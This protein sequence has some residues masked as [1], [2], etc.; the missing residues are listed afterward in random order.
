[1][2]ILLNILLLVGLNISMAQD[3]IPTLLKISNY[4][5]LKSFEL[6]AVP[7]QDI[8]N[9]KVS[10][11][12]KTEETI[13]E[14]PANVTV[15]EN[16]DIQR[17]GYYTLENL[18][19]ITSGYS[20]NYR[21]GEAGLETRGQTAQGFNNNKHL[22]LIDG[23]PINFSRSYKAQIMEELPLLFAQRVEFLKGPASALYGV[24]AFSGV[25]NILPKQIEKSPVSFESKLSFGSL[26]ATKRWMSTLTIKNAKVEGIIANGY[27]EKLASASYLGASQNNDFKYW[28]NNKSY[29]SYT[30][31]TIRK[32]I[33][34]GLKHGL[35]FLNRTGGWG[36]MFW[37]N[38]SSQINKI[39]WS[40]LTSYLQFKRELNSK[41]MIN[42]YLKLNQSTEDA[43]YQSNTNQN[44][45]T[46][47]SDYKSKV[48]NAEVLSEVHWKY[49][50]QSSLIVGLNYDWR[51]ELGNPQSYAYNV[52]YV[53]GLNPRFVYPISTDFTLPS[54]G[55][56][57]FSSFIQHKTSLPLLKG[58]SITSGLR[59][60]VGYNKLYT[61]SKLSPR[62]ALVQKVSN[63]S[64][65]KLLF[66]SALRAPGIKEI[67]LNA[68]Y[69][70]EVQNRGFN[71]NVDY[72]LQAESIQTLECNYIYNA[73]KVH[74]GIAT[75]YNQTRNEIIATELSFVSDSDTLK[76]NWIDNRKGIIKAYGIEVESKLL[77]NNSLKIF[78][79]TSLAKANDQTNNPL[80]GI[81]F[82][83]LFVGVAYQMGGR[84]P[85]SIYV[86]NKLLSN[87]VNYVEP[88][89]P[90]SNIIDINL[91]APIIDNVLLELQLKNILDVKSP[92]PTSGVPRA[93]R[94]ILVT[95]SCK[96]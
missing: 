71:T 73:N 76:G 69:I 8:V 70:N 67:G 82:T 89:I 48:I 36:E 37:G 5:T 58:L 57:T 34:K 64:Y 88:K 68:Q 46:A 49:G 19:D 25:I 4:D 80:T 77:I 62:I 81:P 83:K 27:F 1:M 9:P 75:Y 87:Y 6:L 43:I 38:F 51:K 52:Q 10:V 90:A 39:E 94:S 21:L 61:Y 14:A 84:W 23:I 28:D 13:A 11:A 60:D 66:G 40:N 50:E 92:I 16:T 18:A 29:F 24:S 26:D 65:L 7:L 85:G 56:N 79:N 91:V 44:S 59:L 95:F 78:C 17:M 3:S 2:R 72:N 45:L 63:R 22:L 53:N 86:V 96:I 32:G 20:S 42:N 30:S 93:G 74:L 12:S 55:F 31:F 15:Y 35:I 54:V 41:L 33:L 47:L